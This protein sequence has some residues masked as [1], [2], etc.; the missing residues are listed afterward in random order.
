[1]ATYQQDR[2]IRPE[3]LDVREKIQAVYSRHINVADDHIIVSARNSLQRPIRQKRRVNGHAGEAEFE[4]SGKSLEGEVIIVH[5]Q[6]ESVL[7]GRLSGC[8][9]VRIKRGLAKGSHAAEE[10]EQ[11]TIAQILLI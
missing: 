2:E 5:Q 10:R 11:P 6:N 3:D 7:H 9:T 8:P 4:R 1:M